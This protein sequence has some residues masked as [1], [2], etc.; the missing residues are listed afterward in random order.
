MRNEKRETKSEQV[1]LM[2]LLP[3]YIEKFVFPLFFSVLSFFF[4]FIRFS[5]RCLLLSCSLA[6]SLAHSHICRSLL[7][8]IIQECLHKRTYVLDKA[9]LY[10][11]RQSAKK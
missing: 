5:L 3:N 11:C 2:D 1:R 4:H 7:W 9:A 10:V 8:L 6:R